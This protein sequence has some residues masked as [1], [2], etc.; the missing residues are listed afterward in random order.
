MF[1]AIAA[2]DGVLI[3]TSPVVGGRLSVELDAVADSPENTE[4]FLRSVH[5]AVSSGLVGAQVCSRIDSVKTVRKVRIFSVASQADS[6]ANTR[7]N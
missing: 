3:L 1:V 6:E 2:F 7:P 4:R 5:A